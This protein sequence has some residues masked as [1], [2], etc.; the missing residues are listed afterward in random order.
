MTIQD[1][2]PEPSSGALLLFNLWHSNCNQ[3]DAPD[4]RIDKITGNKGLLL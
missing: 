2:L 3:L 4:E 1:L